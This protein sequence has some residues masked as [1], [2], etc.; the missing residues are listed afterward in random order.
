M[1]KKHILFDLYY[2]IC[3]FKEMFKFLTFNRSWWMLI[4]VDHIL[5]FCIIKSKGIMSV[6]MSHA[7]F[8]I[9]DENKLRWNNI[10]TMGDAKCALRSLLD[11]VRYLMIVS[12]I[13]NI[14]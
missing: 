5:C 9:S 6:N 8:I 1:R 14:C 3:V 10:H 4:K 2:F 13:T 12:Y 7:V 11:M